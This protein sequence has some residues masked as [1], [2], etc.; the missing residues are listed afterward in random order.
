MYSVFFIHPK[1]TD[2]T[3]LSQLQAFQNC[4][5]F[6]EIGTL[7]RGD[8]GRDGSDSLQN[9]A[10]NCNQVHIYRFP[11][12]LNTMQLSHLQRRV[13]FPAG[14][15]HSSPFQT[16]NLGKRGKHSKRQEPAFMWTPSKPAVATCRVKS[17]GLSS[18]PAPDRLPRHGRSRCLQIRRT[19]GTLTRA[20]TRATRRPELSVLRH[21]SPVARNNGGHR[22]TRLYRNHAARQIGRRLGSRGGRTA[23]QGKGKSNEADLDHDQEL[24]APHQRSKTSPQRN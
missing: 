22:L 23:N 14:G 15:H 21:V 2:N 12:L 11:N 3:R 8:F 9:T 24:P 17:K 20:R 13:L 6:I 1:I 7:S 16:R 5:I 18:C 19:F 10:V 4:L